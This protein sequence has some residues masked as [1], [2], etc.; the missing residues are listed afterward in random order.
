MSADVQQT[1]LEPTELVLS[2]SRL[3]GSA[4]RRADSS[5]P[6]LLAVNAREGRRSG[7]VLTQ[8]GES[9]DVFDLDTN[10]DEEDE[11]E[12]AVEEDVGMEE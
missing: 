12:E 10:E 5:D 6:W 9:L 2:R 8:G 11:D 4:R 3:L 7:W 1:T